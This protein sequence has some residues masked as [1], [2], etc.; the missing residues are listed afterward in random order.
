MKHQ[1][2]DPRLSM[3]V[4]RAGLP[5][6]DALLDLFGG[7]K[8]HIPS[9]DTFWERL[10]LEERDRRI[11]AAHD[12]TTDSVKRLAREYGL[13]VRRVQFVIQKQR[14]GKKR[15]VSDDHGAAIAV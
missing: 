8:P 11:Y 4:A 12:G 10:T 5:A 15:S 2:V 9:A 6:L 13:S 7:E 1:Q 14:E 3:L